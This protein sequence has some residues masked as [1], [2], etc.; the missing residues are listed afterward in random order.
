MNRHL[1]QAASFDSGVLSPVG[2]GLAMI[3]HYLDTAPIQTS[4]FPTYPG[5]APTLFQVSR[6]LFSMDP[7]K[8]F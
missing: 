8:E 5:F 4:T 2:L 6:P 3:A 7:L 1:W